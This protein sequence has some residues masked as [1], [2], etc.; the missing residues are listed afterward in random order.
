MLG[1]ELGR[2]VILDRGGGGGTDKKREY[3]NDL[4]CDARSS[5]VSDMTKFKKQELCH[6]ALQAA[7]MSCCRG[8]FQP[9]GTVGNGAEVRQLA[10][11]CYE[12]MLSSEI[13]RNIEL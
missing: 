11:G 7:G 13:L 3:E 8:R 6:S 2:A 10:R 1:Y 5:L 4:T 12:I 9:K